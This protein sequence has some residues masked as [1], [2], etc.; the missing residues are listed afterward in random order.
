MSKRRAGILA[1]FAAPL[2]APP[3]MMADHGGQRKQHGHRNKHFDAGRRSG[4]GAPR[5]I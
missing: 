2:L 4:M 5:W 3:A 1:L